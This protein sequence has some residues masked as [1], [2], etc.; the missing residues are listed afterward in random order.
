VA[1]GRT[2]RNALARR[3]RE[4]GTESRLNRHRSREPL[5]VGAVVARDGSMTPDER[6]TM[7]GADKVFVGRAGKSG[8]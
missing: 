8:R 5:L 1:V 3:E 6:R 7:R 2:T 4:T